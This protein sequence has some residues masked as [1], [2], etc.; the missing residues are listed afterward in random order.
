M[1]ARTP[2]R[3]KLRVTSMEKISRFFFCFQI[4]SLLFFLPRPLLLVSSVFSLFLFGG[5]F[6]ACIFQMT[7]EKSASIING[8]KGCLGAASGEDIDMHVRTFPKV[9]SN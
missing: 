7:N 1:T 8:R 2:K 3:S 9:R 5:T 4:P 6:L